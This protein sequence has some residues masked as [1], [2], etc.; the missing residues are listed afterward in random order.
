[1]AR[2]TTKVPEVRT[3]VVFSKDD[4]ARI[5]RVA[6]FKGVSFAQFIRDAVRR[7]IYSDPDQCSFLNPPIFKSR[8]IPKDLSL[9]HDKYLYGD[10]A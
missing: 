5:R 1:M 2:R 10:K 9:N 8:K 4:H 6:K 3:N 7:E